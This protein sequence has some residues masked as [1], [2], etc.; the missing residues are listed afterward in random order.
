METAS[1]GTDAATAAPMD[2][3]MDVPTVKAE[4]AQPTS[5]SS[6]ATTVASD[7]IAA[8]PAP[9]PLP[10]PPS[11][12]TLP[13]AETHSTLPTY[14]DE[15]MARLAALPDD[16]PGYVRVL[17]HHLVNPWVLGVA[18]GRA[19]DADRRTGGSRQST[20]NKTDDTQQTSANGTT[21]VK[22]DE[23]ASR[24]AP[25][26][27][28]DASPSSVAATA[29]AAS[30][31]PSA[32]APQPSP[33][34]EFDA[35]E[36]A[37]ARERVA[38]E[39]DAQPSSVDGS[40][41]VTPENS[42]KDGASTAGTVVAAAAPDSKESKAE[43]RRN[44]KRNRGQVK[45]ADREYFTAGSIGN[46][47][48]SLCKPIAM[49]NECPFG[50]SCRNNHDL[51]KYLSSRPPDL[52]GPCPMWLMYGECNKGIVCRWGPPPI[53]HDPACR[54]V[55]PPV[56]QPELNIPPKGALNGA[57]NIGGSSFASQK[58]QQVFPRAAALLKSLE[59]WRKISE[60]IRT[61]VQRMKEEAQREASKKAA[62]ERR[63]AKLAAA[64]KSTTSTSTN[65]NGSDASSVPVPASTETS[66]SQSS[67]DSATSPS[68]SSTTTTTS[69]TTAA[70]PTSTSSTSTSS[71]PAGITPTTL[72]PSFSRQLDEETMLKIA[73]L[74]HSYKP[75]TPKKVDPFQIV[76]EDV[77]DWASGCLLVDLE[78]RPLDVR[79]KTWLAPLTT[80]GNLP[81]RRLCT[82][83][84]A[85]I[86]CGEMALCS[87]L[88]KGSTNEWALLK[89]HP[90]EK[91]FGVQIAASFPDQVAR[92]CELIS[93]FCPAL[94]FVDL[95]IG[96]P[97]D[98]VTSKGMGSAFMQ[99]RRLRNI[100]P[101]LR[102][103]YAQLD[104]CTTIKMR[105][106]WS[107][108]EIT[109][110]DSLPLVARS[111]AS[112]VTIHGRTRQQRYT[113]SA[114]R[115]FIQEAAVYARDRLDNL[116]VVANGDIYTVADWES[117]VNEESAIA[118]GL[119]ARGAL[120]KPWIF[121]EIKE[122]RA[123][124]ISS[125]ERLG[126]LQDFVRF[127][128]DHWGSDYSGVENSRRYLL[129]FLSF[130]H[131]YVPLGIQERPWGSVDTIQGIKR[132]K[133]GLGAGSAV[134]VHHEL[135]AR[136]SMDPTSNPLLNSNHDP[137]S[138]DFGVGSMGCMQLKAPPYYARNDLE[139]LMS[140]AQ[141]NDWIRMSEILIG[142]VPDG[143]KFTPKHKASSTNPEA[144][145]N[146]SG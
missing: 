28:T 144:V 38:A 20:T 96:C 6:T 130:L 138:N 67:S 142:P 126:L 125:S 30:P 41:A 110:M 81:F 104:C 3:S 44:R 56:R 90:E 27:S 127:A 114:N 10:H 15:E 87:S 93:Q 118:T 107:T 123:W 84:G 121:T 66:T 35:E 54:P 109:A 100:E 52:P 70:A 101:I 2:V 55:H 79:G 83:L 91:V 68:S 73:A 26:L 131:R 18:G 51:S 75:N 40:S 17:K 97:I 49:G 119:I 102:T 137:N 5:T 36:A 85:D 64:T 22:A 63:A 116:P 135:S 71:T 25:K 65:A 59:K 42:S 143:F 132:D 4:R 82:R 78:R 134:R 133:T 77:F 128:L 69:T 105:M 58:F 112:A 74:Q 89:R 106:G 76:S 145:D 113:K 115:Q 72:P 86:T 95:N 11:Y 31:S 129:E 136:Y 43:A 98:Q 140:S 8:P 48:A 21:N 46:E 80:V 7:S 111:G 62:E 108:Q 24:K 122:R 124:D 32:P 61:G 99:K 39:P 120:I 57:R 45:N 33:G 14:T 9:R 146:P 47:V 117:L 60:R 29:A 12:Y 88:A 37:G 34:N 94:D 53:G 16:D 23:E 1:T 139:Q 19:A 92:S 13:S 103:M 141:V 50:D